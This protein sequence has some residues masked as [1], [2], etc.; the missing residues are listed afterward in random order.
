MVGNHCKVQSREAATASSSLGGDQP[1][2]P[3]TT[4]D[5]IQAETNTYKINIFIAL[6]IGKSFNHLINKS[7]NQPGSHPNNHAVGQLLSQL[8]IASVTN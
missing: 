3:D 2:T 7:D 4:Q 6:A 5:P 1:S 8:I